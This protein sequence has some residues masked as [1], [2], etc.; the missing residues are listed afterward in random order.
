MIENERG[1]VDAVSVQLS[2]QVGVSEG[3]E[4]MANIVFERVAAGSGS[5]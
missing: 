4:D 1:G 5:G 3:V 2:E